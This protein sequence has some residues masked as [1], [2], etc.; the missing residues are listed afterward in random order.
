MIVELISKYLEHNKRLVVPNLGAFIV[1][2]AGRTVLFSNLIK[3]DDGVLRSLVERNGVSQLE[4]AGV[5]DRFVFEV[6]ESLEKS[7]VCALSGFGELRNGANGT[8]QFTYNPSVKGENLDGNAAAK[9]AEREAA[10]RVAQEETTMEQDEEIEISVAPRKEAEP[11]AAPAPEKQ[12][13]QRVEV[14][15]KPEQEIETPRQRRTAPREQN[16]YVKGLRYGKGRKVVTGREGVTSRRSNNGD[17]IIKIAIVAAIIAT[18]ALAYGLYN[19]WRNQQYLYE[20]LRDE[21]IYDE[22]PASA[23]QGVRNPDLDYI[24]P[25]EN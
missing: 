22:V 6:K 25:N 19:D 24:T 12:V 13:E 4:A 14:E 10:R 9:L 5:V 2:E 8:L 16:D 17:L 18:L 15:Q 3:A 7:G 11:Q 21:Q 1:K 23:E 20:D